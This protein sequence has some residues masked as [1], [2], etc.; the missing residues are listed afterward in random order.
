MIYFTFNLLLTLLFFQQPCFIANFEDTID[1]LPDS[2]K[3]RYSFLV[4]VVL[5]RMLDRTF[6]LYFISSNSKR[7]VVLKLFEKRFDH[8][9]F[10][11]D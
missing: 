6:N 4:Q 5:Y 11:G 8:Y 9:I 7:A 3:V 10:E 2:E 1:D